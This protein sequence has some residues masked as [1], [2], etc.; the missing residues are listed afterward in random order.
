[1]LSLCCV[2]SPCVGGHKWSFTGYPKEVSTFLILG[3]VGQRFL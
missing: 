1:M 2:D 3:R